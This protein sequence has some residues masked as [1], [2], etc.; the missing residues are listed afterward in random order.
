M[1]KPSFRVSPS[2]ITLLEK[3]EG[4][5]GSNAA[6]KFTQADLSLLEWLGEKDQDGVLVA[7]VFAQLS[8]EDLSKYGVSDYLLN[9][10]ADEIEAH[11]F[12]SGLHPIDIKRFNREWDDLAAIQMLR[13]PAR[14]H[15]FDTADHDAFSLDQLS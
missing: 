12:L 10:S 13:V 1:L 15:P 6:V 9:S 4:V 8:T 5:G 7:Q 11:A 3:I 14:I 2:D